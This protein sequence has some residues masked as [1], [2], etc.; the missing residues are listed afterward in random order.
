MP[1]TFERFAAETF[2]RG[3]RFD[4]GTGWA[5]SNPGYML[6]KHIV[7]AVAGRLFA[8]L[9]A[10]RIAGPLGLARTFVP[11]SVEDMR[12]LAPATSRALADDGAPRDVREHYHPGWVSHGVVASTPSDI[13][14]FLHALFRGRTVSAD[15]LRE[16]T[17]LVRVRTEPDDHASW[18]E[19]SYGLGIMADPASR[20]GRAWGHNGGGPGYNASAFHAPDLGGVSV[21]AICAEEGGSAER[22]VFAALD[23]LAPGHHP[24][25]R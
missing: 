6:L 17:T 21:C 18:T 3:L 4:P 19:P 25:V 20:W 11:A 14:R 7:E 13:A 12:S 23:A 15:S 24:P 16:M 10:E 1:W 22:L 8:D 2:D 5:Y 9:V